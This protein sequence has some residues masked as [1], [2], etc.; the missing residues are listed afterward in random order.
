MQFQA[1]HWTMD[2]CSELDYL[3]DEVSMDPSS[4]GG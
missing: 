2:K 3:S 4:D 1:M